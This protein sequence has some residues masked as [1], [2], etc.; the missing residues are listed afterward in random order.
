MISKRGGARTRAV[1]FASLYGILLESIIEWV[2]VLYLYGIGQVDSKMTPSLVLSLAASFFSVPL[3]VLHSILAWQ[4]N[5]IAGFGM[6]KTMLHTACTY[7]LRFTILAWLAASVAGLI[8]V[9]QRPTCLAEGA[10]TGYWDSGTS[11]ELHRAVIIVAVVSFATVCSF[12]CSRELCDRPY[13]VSLLGVYK[14]SQ[15]MRDGSVSSG[16]SWESETLKNDILYLCRRPHLGSNHRGLYWSSSDVSAS[17]SP[18]RPPSL[19]YPSSACLRPQL[20]INTNPPSIS[21]DVSYRSVISPDDVSSRMS[22]SEQ[23]IA[24]DFH[25]LSRASTLVT[26]QSTII[27]H[28]PPHSV[29]AE[30]PATPEVPPI[31]EKY[32]HKRAKSSISSLRRFLPKAL[33]FSL[34]LSADPQIRALT[35]PEAQRNANPPTTCFSAPQLAVAAPVISASAASSAPVPE[36]ERSGKG[37]SS[38]KQGL[39]HERSM[40][41]NSADAPEVVQP[42]PLHV[43]RSRTSYVAPSRSIYHPHHPNYIPGSPNPHMTRPLARAPSHGTAT[44]YLAE[45]ER[46][47]RQSPRRSGTLHTTQP[48]RN[49][50]YQFDQTQIPRHTRSQHRNHQQYSNNHHAG[51]PQRI[52]SF[53]HMPPP[54]VSRRSN[55]ELLYPSTRR[56]RSSTFG[57]MSGFNTLD[58]I[59]ESTRL[60]V[61]E[62]GDNMYTAELDAKTYRGVNRTGVRA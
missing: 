55:V 1:I 56:P 61:D 17:D 21:G 9:S 18:I 11:C 24:P 46:L 14:Q 58:S 31:P 16:S 38:M 50:L 45:T 5:Q 27:D 39:T 23:S 42:E 3:I 40:T 47:Q 54:P 19:R 13:D 8:V 10:G 26:R 29:I 48:S 34:P 51:P 7:I 62:Y 28:H 36:A 53:R 20:R 57:G 33:P 37:L 2:L 44:S 25:N 30:L 12:F 43:R 52:G 22:P 15:R 49:D 32:I 35:D 60:S 41:M 59:R 6:Q 4:Y